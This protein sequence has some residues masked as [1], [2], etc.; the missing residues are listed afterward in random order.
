MIVTETLFQIGKEIIGKGILE[1]FRNVALE[2]M[3]KPKICNGYCKFETSAKL[4]LVILSKNET[5]LVSERKISL[6]QASG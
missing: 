4:W 1:I 6:G 3:V 5:S 2:E